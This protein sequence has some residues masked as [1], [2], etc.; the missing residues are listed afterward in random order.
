MRAILVS[1]V[2]ICAAP[3][4]LAQTGD[5]LLDRY[6]AALNECQR[7]YQSGMARLADQPPEHSNTRRARALIEKNFASCRNGAQRHFELRQR[8]QQRRGR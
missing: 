2:L 3:A 1:M 6:N 5:A 7:Q 4:A 8:D